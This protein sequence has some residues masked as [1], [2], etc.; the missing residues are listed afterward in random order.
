MRKFVSGLSTFGVAALLACASTASQDTAVQGGA[1][2]SDQ[3]LVEIQNNRIGNTN[4]RVFIEPVGGIRSFIGEVATSQTSRFTYR[5]QPA[6]YILV[7]ETASGTS[8][9]SEAFNMRGGQIARWNMETNR[10]LVTDR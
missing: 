4:V 10:V 1:V 3:A 7:A 5:A 2:P 6:S 9:R 8:V